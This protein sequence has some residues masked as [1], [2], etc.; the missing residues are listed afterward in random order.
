MKLF[1]S[2]H[3]KEYLFHSFLFFAFILFFLGTIRTALALS[4]L[5]NFELG[6]KEFVFLFLTLLG[7][8]S[9]FSL[10]FSS[11]LALLFVLQRM[12]FEREI[13]AFFTLG[14][15]LKDFIGV[16]LWFCS[17][18]V[19]FLLILSNYVVPTAKRKQ[20]DLKIR[21]Y[22]SLMEKGIPESTPFPL[23]ENLFLYAKKVEG[24]KTLK[25]EKIFIFEDDKDKRGIFLAKE[26]FFNRNKGNL[27]LENG[28]A[29]HRIFPE[30]FE[31]I[32]F[33][34]YDLNMKVQTPKGEDLYYKRGELN[35]KEL[36]EAIE[37]EKDKRRYQR[38]LTEF[39]G[40]FFYPLTIF[41]LL[42]E[43]MFLGILIYAPQRL[44]LFFLGSIFYLVFFGLYNFF[45]SFAEEGH[46]HPMISFVI[47]NLLMAM[48]ILATY[49]YVKKRGF[50]YL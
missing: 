50:A 15:S 38:Y 33:S 13:L 41:P 16:I 45:L 27:K 17:L 8:V 2:Y 18:I 47:F 19:I 35:F 11:F 9:A 31:I 1:Y 42:L 23:G 43:A 28:S 40:R 6:L 37:K 48:I 36:R 44:L 22:Q 21:L 24:D 7:E 20:K 5:V 46:L 25:L 10:S 32:F 34:E 14:Y 12:K 26:G 30:N 39:Y 49:F 3:L 4:E 29:F